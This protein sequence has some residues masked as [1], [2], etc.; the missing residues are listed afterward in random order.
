MCM[1]EARWRR[2]GF[3]TV[4]WAGKPPKSQA[5][6]E[7]RSRLLMA[8]LGRQRTVDVAMAM[9]AAPHKMFLILVIMAILTNMRNIVGLNYAGNY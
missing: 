8:L 2:R 9:I 4:V 5:T 3:S 6:A 7:D 1:S